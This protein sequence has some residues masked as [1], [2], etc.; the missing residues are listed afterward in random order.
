MSSYKSQKD[1]IDRTYN[2]LQKARESSKLFSDVR[3]T[4]NMAQRLTVVE[5]MFQALWSLA[6][7]KGFT[8]EDLFSEIQELRDNRKKNYKTA[9]KYSCPA[10]GK[11]M[12]LSVTDPFFASCMY[13]SKKMMVNP[14]ATPEDISEEDSIQQNG[15]PDQDPFGLGNM[16]DPFM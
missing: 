15:Q 10:C 5:T 2:D 11:T 12:Q 9:P 3:D 6:K 14:L 16:G 7:K 4:A 1:T 8:E 13:C